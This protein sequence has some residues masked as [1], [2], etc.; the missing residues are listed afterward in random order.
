MTP[1]GEI[2]PDKAFEDILRRQVADEGRPLNPAFAEVFDGWI[3]PTARDFK[4]E[5]G[6][7][8]GRRER[9]LFSTVSYHAAEGLMGALTPFAM[10]QWTFAMLTF[11]AV[12]DDELEHGF[13]GIEVDTWGELREL[14][15]DAREEFGRA[16]WHI[17]EAMKKAGLE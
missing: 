7:I 1:P 12:T 14:P 13:H 2:L 6:E 17:G 4:K 11:L 15:A 9:T 10:M 5:D 8:I 3:D 16:A